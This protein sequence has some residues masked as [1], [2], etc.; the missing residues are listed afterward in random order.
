MND[1]YRH[2]QIGYLIIITLFIAGVLTGVLASIQGVRAFAFAFWIVL[3]I[4][5]VLFSAL[6]VVIDR[7]YLEV[8]FGPGFIRKR[9][10]L[11]DIVSCRTVKNPWYYGWGIHLT[12][13]G[14][15]YNVSGFDAVEI[16]LKS[17]RSYR[18]GTD[19]PQELERAIRQALEITAR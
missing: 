2:T 8:R 17:D 19:V 13:H 12:P 16:R 3:V 6:T 15:L 7:E 11:K 10:P 1:V 18:V 5:L 14:W 9:F 4:C